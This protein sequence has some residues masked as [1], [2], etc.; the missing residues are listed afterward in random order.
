MLVL[1]QFLLHSR[2]LPHSLVVQ[3]AVATGNSQLVRIVLGKRDHQ[4]HNNRMMGVPVLLHKLKEV[5][6]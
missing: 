4:R 2:H 3:E 5:W 1:C 6:W